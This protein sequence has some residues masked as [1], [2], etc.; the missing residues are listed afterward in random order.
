MREIKFRQWCEDS[1]KF[2]YWGAN[3][4]DAVFTSPTM[5][6]GCRLETPH[7]QYTGMNDCDGVEIYVNDIVIITYSEDGETNEEIRV[8]SDAG[9]GQGYSPL[10]WGEICESCDHCVEINSIKVI[11][12]IYE[13]LELMEVE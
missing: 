1:K 5:V 3:I 4:G 7:E 10:N 6:G 13:N 2:Y 8:V 9:K 12:N 11:G